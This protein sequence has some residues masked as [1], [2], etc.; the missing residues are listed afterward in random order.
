[1]KAAVR[2]RDSLSPLT[3]WPACQVG[4]PGRAHDC[5]IISAPAPVP[6]IG[7][8]A[9]QPL[10]FGPVWK[11][12]NLYPYFAFGIV[13]KL[14]LF[15]LADNKSAHNTQ[16]EA[17]VVQFIGFLQ[18]QLVNTSLCVTDRKCIMN[19]LNVLFCF[20][21][22]H[23]V[24]PSSKPAVTRVTVLDSKLILVLGCCGSLL[25][26]QCRLIV[27][28]KNKQN[29]NSRTQQ[30]MLFYHMHVKACIVFLLKSGPWK[31]FKVAFHQCFK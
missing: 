2:K 8:A 24:L 18:S 22:S 20:L 4:S 3:H 19:S 28:K 10:T 25:A 9:S 12:F 7:R 6:H 23:L 30:L 15:H 11:M 16:R 27:N 1:M 21:M 29:K 31:L 26:D 17:L 5:F 13:A 14:C